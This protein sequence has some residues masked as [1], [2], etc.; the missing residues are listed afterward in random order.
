MKKRLYLDLD[1]VVY[2]TEN[3]IRKVL[4]GEWLFYDNLLYCE[5]DNMSY[6]EINS[7]ASIFTN[8]NSIPLI[9][10]ASEG[11]EKLKSR[12]SIIFCSTSQSVFERIAKER[13]AKLWGLPIIICGESKSH[14]DM[15]G[16]IFVDN[17]GDHL[18][19]S[20][21]ETKVLFYKEYCSTSSLKDTKVVYKWEELVDYL[22]NKI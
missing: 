6:H 19:S 11:I 10:G 14:I 9:D 16:C 2:N 5:Y 3:Y 7:V 20:N 12:Y 22:I 13:I 8:Y 17:R 18:D 1:D 21:A 4:G 15:E